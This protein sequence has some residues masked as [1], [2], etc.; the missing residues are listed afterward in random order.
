MPKKPTV[1]PT[2]STSTPSAAPTNSSSNKFKI[3]LIWLTTA[4]D[5][6][7]DAFNNA[8]ARW[9][10]VITEGYDSQVTFKEGSTFCGYTFPSTTTISDLMIVVGLAYIDGPGNILGQAGPCAATGAGTSIQSRFGIIELDSAD[11]NLMSTALLNGV[12]LHEIGQFVF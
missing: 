8:V 11:V 6:Q 5:T 4:T 2:L 3:E 10:S 12:I 1:S 7:L 9:E